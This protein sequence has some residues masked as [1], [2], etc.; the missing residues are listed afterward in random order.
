M[1]Y[2]ARLTPAARV[3]SCF[4]SHPNER[5]QLVARDEGA[6]AVLPRDRAGGVDEGAEL[7]VDVAAQDRVGP[8]DGRVPRPLGPPRVEGLAGDQRSVRAL[9][10]ARVSIDHHTGAGLYGDPRRFDTRHHVSGTEGVRRRF[11]D[12]LGAEDL[13]GPEK[14]RLRRLEGEL[15]DTAGGGDRIPVETQAP[16][17][18]G[19]HEDAHFAWV[20]AEGG[21][22]EDR[23]ELGHP[24]DPA[25]VPDGVVH[26]RL[27]VGRPFAEE[28]LAA[29]DVRTRRHVKDVEPRRQDVARL[30]HLAERDDIDTLDCLPFRRKVTHLVT[31]GKHLLDRLHLVW[32]VGEEPLGR[33]RRLLRPSRARPQRKSER[34]AHEEPIGRQSEDT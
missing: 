15:L 12:E 28:D 2:I 8:R 32:R 14:V 23:G 5:G 6:R 24:G 18:L 30:E 13:M 21:H 29:Y 19:D 27:G 31:P 20:A 11:E 33:R 26:E 9:G 4:T 22:D 34:G 7:R 1:R 16:H 3:R 25:Q 17:V 10:A